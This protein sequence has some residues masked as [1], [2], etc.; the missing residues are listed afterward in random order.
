METQLN[1]LNQM[2]LTNIYRAF[3]IEAEEYTLFRINHMPGYKTN[4]SKFN[5]VELFY[6]MS[7]TAIIRL[8]INHKEKCQKYKHVEAKIIC[9]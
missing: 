3:Y 4:L 2:G 5:K 1:T 6:Q 7:F 8:E 9:Y